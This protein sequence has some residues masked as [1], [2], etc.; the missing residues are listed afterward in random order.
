MKQMAIPMPVSP[1]LIGYQLR[2]QVV[3]VELSGAGITQLTATNALDL[4]IGTL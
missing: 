4:T 2:Q 1:T 3:G